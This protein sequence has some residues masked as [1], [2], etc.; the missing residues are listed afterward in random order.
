MGTHTDLDFT[1]RLTK[2]QILS[3]QETRFVK[4]KMSVGT[5]TESYYSN[6]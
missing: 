6:V 5:H 4:I 3:E 2:T 1:V